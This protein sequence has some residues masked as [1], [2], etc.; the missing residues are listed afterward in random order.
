[1]SQI[2]SDMICLSANSA[3]AKDQPSIY[4]RQARPSPKFL[5]SPRMSRIAGS[6]TPQKLEM[7]KINY[8]PGSVLSRT[9]PRKR[10]GRRVGGNLDSKLMSQGE[11]QGDSLEIW[12]ME[13]RLFCS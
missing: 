11:P 4:S 10:C 2:P 3:T 5:A 13:E 7:W 6:P 12:K 8:P 9:G 1:M